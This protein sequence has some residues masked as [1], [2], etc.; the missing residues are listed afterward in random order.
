VA[1]RAADCRPG[2]TMLAG[3]V[4]DHAARKRPFAAAGIGRTGRHQQR[5]GHDS[6]FTFRAHEALPVQ[7]N[8]LH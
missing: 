7:V 1:D 3:D 4:T 5:C 2:N 6:K 8:D